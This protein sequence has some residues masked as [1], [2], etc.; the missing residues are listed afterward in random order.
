LLKLQGGL[1][2]RA[3]ITTPDARDAVVE[4]ADDMKVRW[5]G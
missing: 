2:L 4:Q 1:V 3:I 5:I